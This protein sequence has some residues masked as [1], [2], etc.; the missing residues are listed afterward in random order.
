MLMNGL[1]ASSPILEDA[2]RKEAERS[3]ADW[4]AASS[5]IGA[6]APPARA[7]RPDPEFTAD[8]KR[9]SF[10]AAYKL[11]IVEEADAAVGD[12]MIGAPASPR[13][14]VFVPVVH[15]AA[16]AAA[17]NSSIAS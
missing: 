8:A 1:P 10:P 12:G 3:E 9:R 13:R 2:Q 5:K 6:P 14:S 7:L 16:G 17:R 15:V 11:R 4:S